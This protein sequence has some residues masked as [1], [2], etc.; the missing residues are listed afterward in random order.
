M[1]KLADIRAN[2]PQDLTESILEERVRAGLLEKRKKD[3]KLVKRK[4][5]RI[6]RRRRRS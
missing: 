1:A 2:P 4:G 3:M 5:R 6:S